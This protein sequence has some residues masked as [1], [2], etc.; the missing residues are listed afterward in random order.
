MIFQ[1]LAAAQSGHFVFEL[2]VYSGESIKLCNLKYH[3]RQN[4]H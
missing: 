1:L 4:Y 2:N 3:Y